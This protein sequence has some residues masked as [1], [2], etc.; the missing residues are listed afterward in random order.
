MEESKKPRNLSH[1]FSQPIRMGSETERE[2]R[3]NKI[4]YYGLNWHNF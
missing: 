2:T 3:D 1:D 4:C